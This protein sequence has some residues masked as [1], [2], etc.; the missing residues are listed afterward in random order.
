MQGRNKSLRKCGHALIL[1]HSVSQSACVIIILMIHQP[2]KY[3]KIIVIRFVNC[4]S[5]WTTK[6]RG[7]KSG[8]QNLP[9]FTAT[10]SFGRTSFGRMLFGR[11]SFGRMSFGRQIAVTPVGENVMLL[12]I[13]GMGAMSGERM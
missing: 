8:F 12:P 9:R 6:E 7:K 4:I 13:E 10:A 11:M 2:K 5:K 3:R 1:P